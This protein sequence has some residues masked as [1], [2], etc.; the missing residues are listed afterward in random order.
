MTNFAHVY[1]KLKPP[2]LC[3]TLKPY[4][5]S[6]WAVVMMLWRLLWIHIMF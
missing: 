1:E 4:N 3:H 6:T 2:T 5:L